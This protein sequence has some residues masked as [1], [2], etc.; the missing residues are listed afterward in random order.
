[1]DAL[2]IIKKI[3]YSI[4]KNIVLVWF[5]IFLIIWISKEF[6]CAE[7]LNIV[8]LICEGR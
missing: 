3:I 4:L 7:N 2:F 5:N 6:E 1:M 8:G